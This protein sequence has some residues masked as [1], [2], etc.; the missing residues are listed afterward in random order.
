MPNWAGSCWY[1]LR[2]VDPK[3]TKHLIGKKEEKYFLPV[4]LYVGGA[5]H[6]TRHLIYARFWHKFLYDIGVVSSKE[7]FNKLHSVG[8]ILAED[9]RKMSKRWG[10]VINPDDVVKT[11]GADTLRIYEMFMGPFSQSIAWKTEN[12]IGGR[13]FLEKIWRLAERVDKKMIPDQ[14]LESLI[15]ETIKKVSEDIENF[16]F[17]TAISAMMIFVNKLEKIEKIPQRIYENL[18]L[19]L[20]PFAPHITDEV[21]SLLGHKNFIYL[22]KWPKCELSK[23]KKDNISLVLQVNGKTRGI[24]NVE[25]NTKEEDARELALNNESVKRNLEGKNIVKI[26]YIKDKIVNIVAN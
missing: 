12:M 19:I 24:V 26:I 14:K 6:A 13:R 15:N 4:D 9:G 1:Y 8:L 22:Q 5:E 3:N 20:S 18:L 16:N 23:I 7:P 21:Y 10:N 2:Y 25:P 17:N 11:Y